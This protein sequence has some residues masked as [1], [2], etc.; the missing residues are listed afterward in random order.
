[1]RNLRPMPGGH[2]APYDLVMNVGEPRTS[3]APDAT[4][5]DDNGITPSESAE[6]EA[7]LRSLGY[8]E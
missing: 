8:I 6:I 5:A 3:A 4:E 2:K 7:H 1:M